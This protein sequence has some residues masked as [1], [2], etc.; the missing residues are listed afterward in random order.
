MTTQF[1]RNIKNNPYGTWH[2]H[3]MSDSIGYI[4]VKSNLTKDVFN[5]K[6]SI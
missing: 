5:F 4:P 3:N 1:D 2:A 6:S